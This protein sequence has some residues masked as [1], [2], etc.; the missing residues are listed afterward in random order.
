MTYK[1]QFEP[2]EWH[3]NTDQI[4]YGIITISL[5]LAIGIGVI[6]ITEKT[7]KKEETQHF[8]TIYTDYTPTQT[9]EK[10]IDEFPSLE[11]LSNLKPT[12]EELINNPYKVTPLNEIEFKE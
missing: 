11:S 8:Q 6:S 9:N 2:E 10:P 3:Y 7:V 1:K 12:E 4:K 5:I